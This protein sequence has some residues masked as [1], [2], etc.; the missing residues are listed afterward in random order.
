MT[1]LGIANNKAIFRRI[2]CL[3]LLNNFDLEE[4]ESSH[5]ES[6]ESDIAE[7][8]L[9]FFIFLQLIFIDLF[10]YSLNKNFDLRL[11]KKSTNFGLFFKN[12]QFSFQVV[13]VIVWSCLWLEIG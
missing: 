13:V 5:R 8:Y 1:L 2:A 3:E 4:M 12:F 10:Y 7:K 11:A 9:C 6:S